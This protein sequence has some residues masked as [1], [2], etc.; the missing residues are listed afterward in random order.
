MKR[1]AALWLGACWPAIAR[2]AIA[3]PAADDPW[4]A[5]LIAGASPIVRRV[6][7]APQVFEPQ[8]LLTRLRV[9]G[10]GGYDI[11]SEHRLGVDKRRWF[12]AAS[13]VKLPL[14]ALVCEEL[15]R[16]DLLGQID[17]LR[18]K[19][20]RGSR[21]A[22]LPADEPKGWPLMRLLRSMLIVSDNRSFNAL[23][24][25]VGSDALH[26]RLA[27]LGY[28]DVRIPMRL[29]VCSTGGKA[30]AS[31]VDAAGKTVWDSPA[32]AREMPQSFPFGR[33]LK[34]RA[35]QQ[36]A[37][38][39]PGPHDFS[40]S[41]FMPLED[42]HR[43]LLDMTGTRL[44]PTGSFALGPGTRKMLLQTLSTVPRMSVDPSYPES[45]YPDN[46]S[47]YLG[48]GGAPQRLPA[49]ITITNKN[50]QSYGFLGDSAIIED[51]SAGIAFALS[52]VLYVNHDGVLNDARYEYESIGL[53]FLRDLGQAA[54]AQ[55][56]SVQQR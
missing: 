27:A 36:G 23:Y 44:D 53:P 41:N 4:L 19:V 3:A 45:G 10:D 40:A 46:H 11:V 54:L 15:E 47:K 51:A 14:A 50:A 5:A 55:E 43:I 9:N 30:H 35:W 7:A 2:S 20:A 16:R 24:E 18:L 22:L 26:A 31:L 34:G 56:R 28:Q 21:C 39:V 25:L 38:Q 49:G 13:F 42:V 17:L 29:G 12:A 52:A 6:L 33:A 37:K 8:I 32:S 48:V 1:R